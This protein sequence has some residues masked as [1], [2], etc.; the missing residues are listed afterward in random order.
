MFY[1]TMP[2]QYVGYEDGLV[3]LSTWLRIEFHH[4]VDPGDL[5]PQDIEYSGTLD[6]EAGVI[7]GFWDIVEH[8]IEVPGEGLIDLGC[9]SGTF[10]ME[11]ISDETS[12]VTSAFGDEPNDLKRPSVPVKSTIERLSDPD[13]LRVEVTS[14]REVDPCPCCRGTRRIRAGHVHLG[15]GRVGSFLI[16]TTEGVGQHE[17]EADL[18]FGA[19]ENDAPSEERTA[20]S[21][22]E[23]D[24]DGIQ[25]VTFLDASKRPIAESSG[26]GHAASP[27]EF[28]GTMFEV[29]ALSL[30]RGIRRVL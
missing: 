26:V 11:K 27:D 29:Y 5:P 3:D 1:K 23:H 18:I 4:E 16:Y 2:S 25:T 7:R 20:V 19:W 28:E 15:T 9:G 21:L 14:T 24:H 22:V 12:D 30:W 17:V 8:A 13:N 6:D 10:T